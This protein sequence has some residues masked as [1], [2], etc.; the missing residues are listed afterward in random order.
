LGTDARGRLI[1]ASI[2]RREA[3]QRRLLI[4]C[5][6][7]FDSEFI[8]SGDKTPRLRIFISNFAEAIKPQATYFCEIWA[9]ASD[10]AEISAK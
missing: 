4:E 2:G 3:A 6:T 9:D 8:S 7:S 5:A 10:S 1:A